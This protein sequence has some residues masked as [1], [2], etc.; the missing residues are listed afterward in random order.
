MM[1]CNGGIS[2]LQ[3]VGQGH[4][5]GLLSF[6]FDPASLLIS[7]LLLSLNVKTFRSDFVLAPICTCVE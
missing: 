5:E 3:T 6:D 2:V 4:L 7:L 1:I